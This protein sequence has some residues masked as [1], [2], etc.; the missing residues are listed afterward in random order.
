LLACPEGVA[1]L[2]SQH[3]DVPIY[4]AAVDRQLDEHGYIRPG[5]GDAGDR[6]FGTK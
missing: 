3:P 1:H 5:L 6:I 4:T 2:S